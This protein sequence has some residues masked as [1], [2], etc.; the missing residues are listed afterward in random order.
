MIQRD[1]VEA[2][3]KINGV[4]PSSP[5]EEIRSVLLS[6]R[7][8]NDE[9]DAAIMVLRENT[10]TNKTRVDGLH[11]VF[12]SAETLRP[13][14]ISTLL[15]IDVDIDQVAV[16]QSKVRGFSTVQFLLVW[17]ISVVVSL[18]GILYYMYLNEV[19]VFH[20][21]SPISIDK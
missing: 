4:S 10:R 3:L 6:A 9:V 18:A 13:D 14:E 1:K 19:G 15:G 5:D 2:L 20:P 12:R 8:N 11:K 17:V 16:P 21:T 7:Y